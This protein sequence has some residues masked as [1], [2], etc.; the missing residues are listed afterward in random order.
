[1]LVEYVTK[2]SEMRNPLRKYVS[3]RTLSAG[4]HEFIMVFAYSTSKT[5]VKVTASYILQ[6]PLKK[7]M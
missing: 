5:K 4:A 2:I 1:M 3:I 6:Y 7:T